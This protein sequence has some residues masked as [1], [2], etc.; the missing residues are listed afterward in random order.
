[1]HHFGF[2]KEHSLRWW[3]ALWRASYFEAIRGCHVIA[4]LHG[5]AHEPMI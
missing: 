3:S 5:H 1:M 2:D 4:I